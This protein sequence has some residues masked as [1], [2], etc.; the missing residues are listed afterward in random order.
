MRSTTEDKLMG[1]VVW[2]LGVCASASTWTFNVAR[3]ILALAPENPVTSIFIANQETAI[4]PSS[5]GTIQLVKSHEIDDPR[6]AAELARRSARIIVTV[7]DPRD[8]VASILSA[9]PTNS[10]EHAL[11]LV[12]RSAT[13]CRRLAADPRTLL[14]EY[15]SRFFERPGIVTDIG[16]HLGRR[17]EASAAREI[18]DAM[19]RTQV[20]KHIANLPG[21]P[22]V[23]E[24]PQSGDLLDPVT[25]WHTHH[26]GRTGEIGKWRRIL[27]AGQ[28]DDIEQRICTLSK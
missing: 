8:A 21:L 20:E 3:R 24:N 13:L 10:F 28:I 7:R 2:C 18:Y 23:L 26:A 4:A 1:R 9:Q 12:A 25:H 17:V 22:G 19:T 16:G 15:E 6:M 11:D 5:P 27:S 14:L